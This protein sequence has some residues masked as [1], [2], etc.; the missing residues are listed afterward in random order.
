MS[1]TEFEVTMDFMCWKGIINRNSMISIVRVH[2]PM[3]LNAVRSNA[4][5]TLPWAKQHVMPASAQ[6]CALIHSHV[7]NIYVHMHSVRRGRGQLD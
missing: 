6:V 7:V 3:R 4:T 5:V 1:V 2:Y